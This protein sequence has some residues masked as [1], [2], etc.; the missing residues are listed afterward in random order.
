MS[1]HK[2][3]IRWEPTVTSTGFLEN[4]HFHCRFAELALMQ[5]VNT[6]Q[7]VCVGN[8]STRGGGQLREEVPAVDW[9]QVRISRPTLT[10]L[11][12]NWQQDE[13]QRANI[14]GRE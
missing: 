2:I 11:C 9:L 13:N 4:K 3:I 7:T 6:D 1:P 14:M 5:R 12:R 10:R 8:N